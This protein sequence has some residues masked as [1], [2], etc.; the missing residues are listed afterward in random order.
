MLENLHAQSLPACC[1]WHLLGTEGLRT[2]SWSDVV[3]TPKFSFTRYM[4]IFTNHHWHFWSEE[5]EKKNEKS[6]T[7]EALWE[8]SSWSQLA[9]CSLY[10]F[11]PMAASKNRV[12]PVTSDGGR[13]ALWGCEH[14]R[15]VERVRE[16]RL[17]NIYKE[18]LPSPSSTWWHRT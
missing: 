14:L 13:I 7:K 9:V 12:Q 2:L 6:K 18:H 4:Q 16:K 11:W 17:C 1:D 10:W 5:E 3:K 15:D 8:N